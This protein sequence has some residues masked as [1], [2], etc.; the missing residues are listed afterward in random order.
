[1]GIRGAA[2]VR[3]SLPRAVVRAFAGNGALLIVLSLCVLPA[4]GDTPR[5]AGTARTTAPQP[6]VKDLRGL[7][8]Q[9]E[10]AAAET[11][12]ARL[13]S[14]LHPA[15]QADSLTMVD[16]TQILIQARLCLGRCGPDVEALAGNWL[17]L[18]ETLLGA[19]AMEVGLA[20]QFLGYL[21][22]SQSDLPAALAHY[23]KALEVIR[24]AAGEDH[25]ETAKALVNLA[26]VHFE[27]A[28][29]ATAR[30]LF[31]RA[32]AI[33]NLRLGPDDLNRARTLLNLNEAKIALMDSSGV[34]DGFSQALAAFER[35]EG[36][37]GPGVAEI[38]HSEARWRL[39][40]HDAARAGRLLDRAISIREA[41]RGSGV[42]LAAS[43]RLRARAHLG[44][45]R[46][47][48]ARACAHRAQRV[49]GSVGGPWDEQ[50]ADCLVILGDAERQASRFA[51]SM[52]L[53]SQALHLLRGRASRDPAGLT[54][55][56]RALASIS[57]ALA[58]NDEALRYGLEARAVS[59]DAWGATAL[60]TAYAR[61]AC[62]AAFR[63][64][65]M[66]DSASAEYDRV[67]AHLSRITGTDGVALAEALLGR[68]ALAREQGDLPA[69]RADAE[70][71]LELREHAFGT[72]DPRLAP[73]LHELGIAQRR[74]G[75]EAAARVALERSLRLVSAH[76]NDMPAEAAILTSLGTAERAQGNVAAAEAYF[77]QAL[78]LLESSLPPTHPQIAQVLRN[79]ASLENESGRF[80][81]AEADYRRALGIL[82]QA[83]PE[84]P[85]LAATHLGLGN[86]LK[87]RGDLATA[88]QH[89]HRAISIHREA[90]GPESA[91]MAL[92]YYNLASLMLESGDL[93]AAM[94]TAA[95]AERLSQ[96]YFAMVAQGVS[97]REA[98]HYSA[99][100]VRGTDVVLT[101]VARSTS[102][103]DW[104]QAW[105]LIIHSRAAVLEEISSRR[106]GMAVTH[107]PD[108]VRLEER[109]REAS[110]RLAHLAVQ[111]RGTR[112]REEFRRLL[113]STRREK[114]NAE[115]DLAVLSASYRL[116]RTR[117]QAG[118]REVAHALPPKSAL[119]AWVRFNRLERD[120]TRRAA[121]PGGG[122]EDEVDVGCYGAFVLSGPGQSPRFVALGSA[123]DVDRQIALWHREAGGGP[124]SRGLDAAQQAYLAAG[125]AVRR[126]VWDPVVS[127]SMEAEQIFLVPDGAL[128][129]LNFY[130]LPDEQ[131][132]Y[133]IED[134]PLL[135][136]L[137]AER[138]LLADDAE[139]V[140]GQG[141][142]TAAAPDFQS[143]PGSMHD[144]AQRASP[145]GAESVIRGAPCG[146]FQRLWFNPLPGTA[147]EQREIIRLWTKHAPPSGSSFGR[148]SRPEVAEL[149]GAAA[150]ERS[151]RSLARG[152]SALHVATHGFFLGSE[153]AGRRVALA[154][155]AEADELALGGLLAES[156]LLLSGLAFAGANRRARASS[157]EDD[158][159]LTAEEIASL[160]LSGVD[161]VVL[162][163]CETGLGR[164]EA[165]EGV[166]GF[167]RAFQVAGVRSLV[168][169][170]WAVDDDATARWMESMFEHRWRKRR[171]I[172]ESVRAA[173][174]EV[175]RERERSG[176]DTH[177]F[178]WGA[179]VS[180]GAWR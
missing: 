52:D 23:Q 120:P 86:A 157:A 174:L 65:Q 162:S 16:A 80:A 177:P 57:L 166:F 90:L 24:R 125:Q 133:L 118:Y 156:P 73:C 27:M 31:E 26:T 78:G 9:G 178:Y 102:A 126:A 101:C 159:I 71:A 131:G 176:L 103:S 113:Q 107:D 38:L 114:E 50:I 41:A 98:L 140:V 34:A 60:G 122:A 5:A 36:A 95:V 82:E 37:C 143:V 68:A 94:D 117:Q 127:A 171:T 132:R 147:T 89:Y 54:D 87:A 20:Q 130:T 104:Q 48:S 12:A 169:S 100:R 160:D 55:C 119:V 18:C 168:M 170:L 137:S 39:L 116:H 142:L 61:I 136:V 172:A 84:H 110:S 49:Y 79:L 28:D 173:S 175:L 91:A 66:P 3:A 32:L 10:W 43:L 115:R 121:A 46:T 129:L 141:L 30:G 85:D 139:S 33:Q 165:G 151:F 64:A 155:A 124:R 152:R 88:R 77:R 25:P 47:D 53:Y 108:L 44:L 7:L 105:D 2:G 149:A 11:G 1:M 35:A 69:A 56:L 75:D 97:E 76:Q 72:E 145:G 150:T 123:R 153:C 148:N 6:S 99:G 180:T 40:M 58:R 92:D 63:A 67:I 134:A 112:S 22:Q 158:G 144:D 96:R 111:G 83:L 128:T 29:Y 42:D 135:H 138:D 161:L 19:D 51:A 167:R 109:L 62:A 17:R 70:R 13:V 146:E 8:R 14:E 4:V 164:I 154:G 179:F 81:D 21:D 59:V 74:L 93:R 15:N 163:A 45:V 106:R